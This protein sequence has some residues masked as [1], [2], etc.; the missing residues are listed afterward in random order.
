V[1]WPL[2]VLAAGGLAIF[3]ATRRAWAKRETATAI[4]KAAA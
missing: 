3:I 1:Y 2:L 4:A